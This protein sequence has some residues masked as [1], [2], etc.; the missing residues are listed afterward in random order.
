MTNDDEKLLDETGWAM[1]CALQ[2]N[3]RISYADLGRKVGLTPPAVADRIRRLEAAGIITGYHATVNPAKLGLGLTAIIRFKGAN[4]TS[5]R[6]IDVVKRCPE[7]VECHDLTG[8]DCMSLT[9]VV[10]SVSHLQ[11][12]IARLMPFG[13]SNT[14]IVLASPLQHRAIGPTALPQ[15]QESA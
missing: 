2:E 5:E 6:I 9:V 7:I 15:E 1:L 4:V 8:D 12:V 14:S 3:A 13:A 10:A 11:S